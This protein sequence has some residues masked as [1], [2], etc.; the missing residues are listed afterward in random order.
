MS[1]I[2]SI[3]CDVKA[4]SFSCL[5]PLPDKKTEALY[6]KTQLTKAEFAEKYPD[7]DV[8]KVFF[9]DTLTQPELV[10]WDKEKMVFVPL[11][12]Y[13]GGLC[14]FG[15]DTDFMAEF[16]DA[17]KLMENARKEKNYFHLLMP[18]SDAMRME[19][20]GFILEK[21]G[22]SEKL[23]DAFLA[24]YKISD[25][26]FGA[27]DPQKI[28]DLMG[29]MSEEKR[30]ERDI[31]LE[32]LPEKIMLYRGE[33]AKSTPSSRAMSWS[34]S[35]NVALWYACRLEQE[36][37]RLIS[38]VCNKEDVLYAFNDSD[39]EILVNPQ[40][41]AEMACMPIYGEDVIED[42]RYVSL[43]QQYRTWLGSLYA[44]KD[45]TIFNHDALHSARVLFLALQIAQSESHNLPK[46]ELETLCTAAIFH[47]IGRTDDGLDKQHGKHGA[48]IY[49]KY[50]KNTLRLFP[51][52]TVA[53]LIEA[54][55]LPD[56]EAKKIVP[57]NKWHLLD[58]LKDADALDRVRF[59][60]GTRDGLDVRF[61]RRP[62]S[63]Q[64]YGVAIMALH[65]IE[66]N[67]PEN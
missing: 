42:F 38:A 60:Y 14:L 36:G 15:T 21:D 2:S 53:Q 67:F 63:I 34:L 3:I 32:K 16:K 29:Y 48:D 22:P 8:E 30:K 46:R 11:R 54:H 66:L 6:E 57:E 58:I 7:I 65:G 28:M 41:L 47:D 33:G 50:M 64:L 44:E 10:W 43:Y 23:C 24:W 1:T 35:P 31:L 49:R 18:M 51:S 55:N 59:R 20:L 4:N 39:K 56:S 40:N 45:S 19:A 9:Q 13:P 25:Y 37:C 12:I 61:L 52:E 5:R 26:G 17:L 62:Q 27:L